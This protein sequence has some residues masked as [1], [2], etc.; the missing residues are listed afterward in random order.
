MGNF[1][2]PSRLV[3]EVKANLV[4]NRV[5]ASCRRGSYG[6][7]MLRVLPWGE[8]SAGAGRKASGMIR[9]FPENF[10]NHKQEHYKTDR[11]KT[12]GNPQQMRRYL[13]HF[14]E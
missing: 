1:F 2:N 3:S 7:Q 13:R 8:Y 6:F 12:D 10:L 9:N 11:G 5:S 14:S 4:G